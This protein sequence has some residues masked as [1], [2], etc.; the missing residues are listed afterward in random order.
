MSKVDEKRPEIDGEPRKA[1]LRRHLIENNVRID[2]AHGPYR[3]IVRTKY[4]N[5]YEFAFLGDS[6]LYGMFMD[7]G[8]VISCPGADLARIGS[9]DI[10]EFITE[11][12]VKRIGILGGTNDLVPKHAEPGQST[13]I[14]EIKPRL[15]NIIN[16]YKNA[17]LKVAICKVPSRKG[18]EDE[19][20][21]MNK[22]YR[23]VC[24][25]LKVTFIE[26]KKF[27]FVGTSNDGL[28]PDPK[29]IQILTK[30][31]FIGLDA[32]RATQ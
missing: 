6:I 25:E 21:E 8:M 20:I 11:R 19:I 9:K 17:G 15:V 14:E 32:L 5:S 27:T 2:E 1:A 28:H 10:E 24:K 18:Y 13:P 23:K 22:M 30:D 7:G 16:Q 4:L 3:T 31:L 26:Y 12:G 29:F